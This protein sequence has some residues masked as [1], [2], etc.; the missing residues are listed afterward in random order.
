MRTAFIE[1][2]CELAAE[3]QRIWLLCGDLGF[4]VLERFAERFPQRYV[5]VGV[6][7]QNMTGIAAGLA[8]CG[9]IVF[10]Y[11]IANFPTIRCLEQIRNDVCYHE[12]SVK[13]VSVGGGYA[14]GSQGYT[15]HGVEDLAMLRVLPGMT[16]VAPGDPAETRLV[17]RAIAAQPG[18]GY[19]RLGKAGEPTVHES[20]PAFEMGRALT[21][22]DG[23]DVTLISTG[24]MLKSVCTAADKLAEQG[25]QARVL[26]MHTLK[27]LDAA[28]V[29]AAAEQTGAILTVE[30][31]RRTGGLGSAVAE[32]LADAG[33]GIPFARWGAPDDLQHDVGGQDFMRSTCGNLVQTV[34][35]LLRRK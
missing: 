16:V 1:T 13:I 29:R 18:P 4:S 10:T 34:G 26:S 22:R 25:I 3:D 11:S 33:I 8:R 17:T 28:A 19:L 31:H 23:T 9:K 7:E 20:P 15:H 27:P 21:V 32:T 2:L 6:A 5:N 30:E 12:A 35:E 14:Y 24:G